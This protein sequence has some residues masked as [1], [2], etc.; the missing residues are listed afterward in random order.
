M[1]AVGSNR[2][3]QQLARKFGPTGGTVPVLRCWLTGFDT[4]YSAHLS[5]YGSA[6][7]TLIR[8]PGTRVALALNWLT[9]AQ[10]ARMHETELARGNYA[11]GRLETVALEGEFGLKVD[12]PWFY[13]SRHGALNRLGAPVP[14][15]WVP[16][17][18]RRW[19]A[20]NQA[21]LQAELR[22]ALARSMGLEAFVSQAIGHAPR[23]LQR[24]KRL[25]RKAL[26]LDLNG[27]ATFIA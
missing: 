27:I 24:T 3:P 9:D 6:P 4:V 20:L 5:A 11:F 18:Q 19:P 17:R 23:R 12:G 25:K 14:L 21:A 2:A 1:L 13:A 16:A 15:A 26:S 7:A 10:L 22:N 8:S